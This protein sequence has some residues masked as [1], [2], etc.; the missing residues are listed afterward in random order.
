M[1]LAAREY[2]GEVLELIVEDGA[3]MALYAPSGD[4]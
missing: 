3:A 4:G 1:I 2:V